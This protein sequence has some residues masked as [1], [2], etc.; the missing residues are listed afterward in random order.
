[1]GLDKAELSGTCVVGSE[2][3]ITRETIDTKRTH[4]K[5]FDASTVFIITV[6]AGEELR[7]TT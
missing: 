4:F 2:A 7:C 1:M 3:V 6:V 5:Q